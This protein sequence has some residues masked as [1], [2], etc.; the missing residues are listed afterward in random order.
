MVS[1]E[2]AFLKFENKN[3]SVEEF[4]HYREKYPHRKSVNELRCIECGDRI[5]FCK[6]EKNVPYFKHS[7]DGDCHKTCKLYH[8][9]K[10]SRRL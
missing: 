7:I 5:T 1:I 2:K 4:N 9:G 8:E 3:V 6:G 10:A